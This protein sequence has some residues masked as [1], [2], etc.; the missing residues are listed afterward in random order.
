MNVWEKKA[1]RWAQIVGALPGVRAVFLSGSLAQGKG[2]AESD[3]DFF[4]ITEPGQIWTARFFTNVLLK[5]SFNLSKPAAHAGRICPNHFITADNLEIVEQ[6]AYSAHLFSHNRPLYDPFSLWPVFVKAN[7][8]VHEFGEA[9][10]VLV[11]QNGEG[12][13]PQFSSVKTLNWSERL[14]RWIQQQKIYRNPAFKKP[15]AKIV[16][17]NTELRFHPDPKNQYWETKKPVDLG[18]K[19]RQAKVEIKVN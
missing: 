13:A 9:F 5:L 16:L 18:K 15:D 11:K 3:I 14:L 19:S 7:E 17:K 1:R 6:E 4:I 10:P 2:S 8:W 12:L